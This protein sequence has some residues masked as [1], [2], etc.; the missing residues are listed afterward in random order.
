MAEPVQKFEVGVFNQQVVDQMA[1]GLRHK[2]LKDDWAENHYFEVKAK[3][4]EEAR[5]KLEARVPPSAGYVISSVEP[6]KD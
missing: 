5:R 1:Q 3:S 4:P 2:H 6:V